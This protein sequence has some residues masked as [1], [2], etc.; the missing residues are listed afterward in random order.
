[1]A[2]LKNTRGLNWPSVDKQKQKTGELDLLDWLRVT[3]GFQ[4]EHLPNKKLFAFVFLLFLKNLSITTCYCCLQRDN[5]RNQREHLILLLANV[6][7]RLSPKPEPLT[8]ARM[9]VKLDYQS[10]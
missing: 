2:A 5:V 1:M 9:L 6:H 10:L 3:F 8:K 7:I 4:V